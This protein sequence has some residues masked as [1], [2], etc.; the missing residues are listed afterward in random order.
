VEASRGPL[1]R[2]A[3][4]LLGAVLLGAAAF[5]SNHVAARGIGPERPAPDF[6]APLVLNAE[7]SAELSLASLQGR[8]VVLDFWASWCGPCRAEAPILQR[9][10]ARYR[11]QGLT[12]VGVNTSD[13]EGEAAPAARRLG[14]QFPIVYDA[15][16]VARAY[17]VTGL[18]TLVVVSRT[19]KIVAVRT[20]TTPESTL[21]E[22]VRKALEG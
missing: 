22:L 5:G 8:A 12:V 9:L 10:Y 3:F 1:S 20:G 16:K 4:A 15:G 13:G 7:A 18:P 11:D 21:E 17:G 2:S 14:L 19:G 6:V